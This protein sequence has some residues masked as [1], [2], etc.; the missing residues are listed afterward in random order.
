MQNQQAKTSR[1]V[2][3][4]AAHLHTHILSI[5]IR[6]VVRE[7]SL[8]DDSFPVSEASISAS[9]LSVPALGLFRIPPSVFATWV[10]VIPMVAHGHSQLLFHVN[11]PLIVPNPSNAFKLRERAVKYTFD[12]DLIPK[13]PIQPRGIRN[14]GF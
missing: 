7:L 4:D 3:I 14:H 11:R 9:N 5:S 13:Q 12:T 1:N 10:L 6:E 2:S 8:T